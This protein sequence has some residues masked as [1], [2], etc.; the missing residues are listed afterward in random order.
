MLLTLGYCD[1]QG[2][3]KYAA[4]NFPLFLMAGYRKPLTGVCWK[5]ISERNILHES[6]GG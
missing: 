4:Q 1:P 3:A 6:H 2:E 5:C